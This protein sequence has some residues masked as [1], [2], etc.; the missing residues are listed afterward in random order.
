M[1]GQENTH[2][3][4]TH[5]HWLGVSTHMHTKIQQMYPHTHAV[6][7][8]LYLS[9]LSDPDAPPSDLSVTMSSN[10][11]RIQWQLPVVITGPT[12]YLIDVLSLD[13]EGLNQSVVRGP[14]ELRIVVVSNLT[15]FT[16]YSV[17]VTAFTGP[18]ENARRDGRATEPTV[19]RTMEEGEEHTDPVIQ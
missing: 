18:L 7:V 6:C 14:E 1:L 10:S 8:Y 3:G 5:T 9:L 16:R 11:L 4:D 19:I 12:S 17:T 2:P 15:A 13:S